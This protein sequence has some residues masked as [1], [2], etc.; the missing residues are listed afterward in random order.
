V[1]AAGAKEIR[2]QLVQHLVSHLLAAGLAAD[3]HNLVD[4]VDQAV[5]VAEMVV[6]ADQEQ[7]VKVT[8]AQAAVVV[9]VEPDLVALAAQEGLGHLVSQLG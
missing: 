7:R 9:V 4:L 6:V 5:A 3:T 1:P 2:A 8:M